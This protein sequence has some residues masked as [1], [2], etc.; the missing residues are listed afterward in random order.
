MDFVAL[1][2]ETAD[3]QPDSACAV[4]LVRVEAG[5]IVE[6]A[7]RLIRPPRSFFEFT[8]IHH[9]D[10]G[11]VAGEPVFADLWPGLRVML[12]GAR[13]IAAHNSRFDEAVLRACCS[14]AGLPPPGIPFLCTVALARKAWGIRPTKLPDVCG[15]LGIELDHHQALSDAEACARIVVAAWKEG[16]LE[17]PAEASEDAG[18]SPNL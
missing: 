13:F 11:Q 12:Q 17:R 10:W 15:R 9:I 4:G 14:R 3:R 6:R 7:Y 2:F 18:Q 5:E 1:D 16:L 8:Y